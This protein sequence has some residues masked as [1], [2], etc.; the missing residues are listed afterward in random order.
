QT[1]DCTLASL[2][3]GASKTFTV[4]YSV[5]S[6]VAPDLSVANTASAVTNG[7]TFTGSA[8][9]AITRNVTLK[10]D[11]AFQ[12]TSVDAGTGGHTFTITVTNNGPSDAASVHVTDSVDSRLHVTAVSDS[13]AGGAC[14]SSSG[15]TIDCTLASLANGASKTF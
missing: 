11:K 12:D 7:T 15:Q 5:G 10:V 14:A 1:I 6:S 2:A 4:T 9:V 3:N 13:G 8:T